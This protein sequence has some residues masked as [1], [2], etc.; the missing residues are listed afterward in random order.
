[1]VRYGKSLDMIIPP[2]YSIT[3]EMLELIAK[4]N[5]I[6]SYFLSQNLPKQLK[7]RI[8]RM[9]LLKSSLFSARIEGNPLDLMNLQSGEKEKK[10]EIFNIIDTTKLID[11]IAAGKISKNLIL[12][13]H[14]Q[15]LK[16]LS[17]DAGNF[18]SEPSAIFNSAG[19]AIYISP[20]PKKIHKLLDSLLDYINSD[21][22]RFPLIAALITHLVFEKIHPFLDGNGRVG[23]LLIGAVLKIKKWN[24]AIS[25]PFE[26]YLEEHKQEYYYYLD[27][28]LD[29]TN[30][31]LIFM[32]EAFLT[33]LEKLKNQ[34]ETDLTENKI[35]LPPRQEEIYNL[36]KRD[37]FVC[38]F[39]MVRRRFLKVPERTLRYDLNKLVEKGLVEKTGQTR[40]RYY[41]VKKM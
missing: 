21:T 8:Q 32:L 19:V 38:S 39:D 22:E 27:K 14:K 26:E 13:L 29:E 28:G 6:N 15:V 35:F 16:N 17:A 36:I 40:G 10:L 37:H 7:I 3:P 24:L 41:R 31:Y 2:K 12:K 11:K 4:I 33:Q 25:V 20:S 34:I 1:M 9:S 30:D 5:A 18:R 23:R